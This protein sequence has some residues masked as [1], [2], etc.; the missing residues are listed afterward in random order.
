MKTKSFLYFLPLFFL[1]TCKN[2]SVSVLVFSKTAAFRHE[3]IK[4]GKEAF[5]KLGK[6]YNIN[7]DTTEDA[8]KFTDLNLKKYKA[9]VFL[10]TTGD[11]LNNDQQAAFERF[12]KKGNGFVGVHAASDC[13]YEWQWFVSL[14]GGNFNGHP[15]IQTADL[16][17]T[18]TDHA[19]T[20]MLP[21]IWQRTDEW[22]NFKNLNPKTNLLIK[23]DE[24]TYLGGTHGVEKTHPMC[25]Y[26]AF[27]GGRAWYT[28][29]GHTNESY[30]EDLFL[31]HLAGGVKYAIGE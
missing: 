13:E 21:L 22:Y 3:S 28:A 10:S 15:A 16:H 27:D 14:V 1:F 4:Y 18:N 19:S 20:K 24:K 7:V 12:I 23:I 5:L 11:I 6:T 29:L 9:V 31:K 30:S 8:S 25:W 17:L 2:G 26:H